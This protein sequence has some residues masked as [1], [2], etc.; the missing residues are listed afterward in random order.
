MTSEVLIG[1]VVQLTEPPMSQ[2]ATGLGAATA[3][4]IERA[5]RV[6]SPRWRAPFLL[7]T[8]TADSN[9]TK[10]KQTIIVIIIIIIIIIIV[11]IDIVIIIIIIGHCPA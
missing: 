8:R 10:T 4:R 5:P 9:K 2:L 6:A 7:A 11:I 1:D 3:W